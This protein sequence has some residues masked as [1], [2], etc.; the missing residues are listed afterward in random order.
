MYRIE[1]HPKQLEVIQDSARYRVLVAGRRFGKSRLMLT[2]LVL[3]SLGY[4]GRIDKQS[5]QMVLG[6]LPTLKQA[7]GIL[8]E[9][10]VSLFEGDLKMYCL[11]I[12]RTQK[13][14]W[15]KDGKPPIQI[16]GANDNDGD[17]LRGKRIYF[18]GADEY[19]DWKPN[20]FNLI[21][22]P[23]MADT[24]GSRALFT[25][26]PKGKLNH[27]FKLYQKAL[28]LPNWSKH[29]YYT[30]DNP[31]IAN[32]ESELAQ[33]EREMTP[34]QIRQ[35][36]FASFEDFEGKVF[37]E[38][39]ESNLVQD[40]VPYAGLCWL[41]IDWGETNP[42]V[43]VW[44]RVP[45]D[46]VRRPIW[47]FEEGWQGNFSLESQGG[48]P[49]PTSVFYQEIIRLANKYNVSG[50]FC[51]PSRP[52]SILEV[53]G[54]GSRLAPGLRATVEGYN[55]IQDGID[56][57]HTLMFQKRLLLRRNVV[58]DNRWVV[59]GADL[60][61]LMSSYHRAKNKDGV[62]IERIEDGQNDHCIDASRYCLMPNPKRPGY[63]PST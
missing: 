63:H 1:L 31:T 33:A 36:W 7:T 27:L 9:P 5:P 24:P 30:I 48:A 57:M 59:S 21:V 47:V 39:E 52:A 26:T 14:I 45:Q 12:D 32:L 22:R 58:K 38:L 49:I 35:E 23:A 54:L 16:C 53:R 2:E 42:A 55:P 6:V 11:K 60:Y 28:E 18:I 62:V 61:Q 44:R 10:L 43:T 13:K 8:W 3:A 51:D 15:L 50:A 40:D 56:Y 17:G 19:Q 29:H 41:G 37:S 34:R 25:G 20:I 4:P 46:D